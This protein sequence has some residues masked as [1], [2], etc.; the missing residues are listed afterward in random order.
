MKSESSRASA[1]GLALYFAVPTALLAGFHWIAWDGLARFGLLMVLASVLI[2]LPALARWLDLGRAGQRASGPVVGIA[3]AV[4]LAAIAAH[5]L[6]A[7]QSIFETQRTGRISLDQGENI[8]HG[9]EMLFAGEDPYGKA[10]LLDPIEYVH[11]VMMHRNSS[12]LG[13]RDPP[14]QA[15]LD[16]LWRGEIYLDP[17][18]DKAFVLPEPR[19]DEARR[20]LQTLGIK[21]GPTTLAS[22]APAVW[23]FGKPGVFVTQLALFL[24]VCAVLA[25]W[26]REL[27]RG[28]LLLASLAF[29]PLVGSVH[30]YVMAMEQSASDLV[31]VLYALLGLFFFQRGRHGW[32]A[33]MIGLSVSAKLMPGLI[34]TPMLLA[35]SARP[36]LLFAATALL[37]FAPFAVWEPSG[38]VANVFVYNLV[39][40]TD[41]SA[42]AYH[43]GA[44][45]RN[46]LLA[47]AV[48]T[49]LWLFWR[50]HRAGWP[51]SA[52]LRTLLLAHVGVVGTA[53]IFHNNYLIWFLPLVGLYA[54][55]LVAD[56]RARASA[57]EP[58]DAPP[59]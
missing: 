44:Y 26:S 39:R 46:V 21:Y 27:A 5:G 14:D 9:L 10:A 24:G 58:V 52:H 45:D 59:G 38:L 55:S 13:F 54:L 40:D 20:A 29:W 32:A 41:R 12:C 15:H 57:T 43:L 50:T 18:R 2:A 11:Q 36:R 47:A 33:A 28:D 4:V 6:A 51:L 48:A 7:V 17:I 19:C 34:Y 1:L 56:E 35:M 42:L 30:V 49:A 3:V 23:L 25:V 22:Y 53:K 8:Y 37:P 16:A 31:G